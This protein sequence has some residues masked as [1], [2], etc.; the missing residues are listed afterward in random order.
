MAEILGPMLSIPPTKIGFD[1]ENAQCSYYP[2]VP[3]TLR[4]VDLISKL[5]ERCGVSQKNTRIRKVIEGGVPLFEILIASIG[6]DPDP[7]VQ[8][9][10]Y[11]GVKVLVRVVRG[12]HSKELSQICKALYKAHKQSSCPKRKGTLLNYM[13][14]FQT[15]NAF[16]FVEAQKFWISDRSPSVES[17]LGFIDPTRDPYGTRFEWEGVV[18]IVN[19]EET[20]MMKV[21]AT[22]ADEFIR[23]L[24]WAVWGGNDGKGRF[25]EKIFNVPNITSLHS[26]RLPSF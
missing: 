11:Q 19:R 24:P 12:D 17:V 9:I 15:G 22:K 8:V 18:G 21:F 4:E 25:K 7:P 16:A 5:K 14:S 1:S 26:S 20:I 23:T 2:G 3:L 13:K 6:S 10:D